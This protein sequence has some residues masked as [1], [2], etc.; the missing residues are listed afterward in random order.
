MGD[1]LL[2]RIQEQ[3]DLLNTQE[4]QK[5]YI[6]KAALPGDNGLIGCK[7]ALDTAFQ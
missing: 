1:F 7:I 4:N 6:K 5:I 3:A 2:E